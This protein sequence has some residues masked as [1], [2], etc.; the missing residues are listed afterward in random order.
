MAV[1]QPQVNPLDIYRWAY[2]RGIINIAPENVLL[3]VI[4]NIATMVEENVIEARLTVSYL[5]IVKEI[6]RSIDITVV[7]TV[8]IPQGRPPN[9]VSF[10]V[11]EYRVI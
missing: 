8:V 6:N 1:R 11:T 10:E 4:R 3:Y 2:N 5:L 7:A 9:V